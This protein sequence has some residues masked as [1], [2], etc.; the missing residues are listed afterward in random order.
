MTLRRKYKINEDDLD[1][2]PGQ[3]YPPLILTPP[4]INTPSDTNMLSH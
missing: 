3:S 2:V 1:C 4:L